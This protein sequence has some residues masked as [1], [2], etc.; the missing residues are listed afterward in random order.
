MK[1]IA[2]QLRADGLFQPFSKE[3]R[4]KISEYKPNQLFH[5]ELHG[6]KKPRSYEQLK[7]IFACARKVADNTE[8]KHW[9]TSGKVMEQVKIELKY[10]DVMIVQLDGKSEVHFK[11]K[12]ISYEALPHM[13]ACHFVDEALPIMAAKIGKTVDELILAPDPDE[14]P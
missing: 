1:R 12:S 6:V 8:D 11:T 10:Y 3:D 4:E 7:L 9:N 2:L 13:E 14:M 5:T